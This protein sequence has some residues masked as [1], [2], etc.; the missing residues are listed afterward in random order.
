MEETDLSQLSEAE[1]MSMFPD[2]IESGEHIAAAKGCGLGA[3]SYSCCCGGYNGC[4]NAYGNCITLG[5]TK[6]R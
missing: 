6:C 1:M 2:I 5:A 4:C 3:G